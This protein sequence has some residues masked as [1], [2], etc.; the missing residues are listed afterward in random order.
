MN[1][2][3]Q[4]LANEAGSAAEHLGLGA[5]S[6][7]RANYAQKAYYTQ[8]FFALSVGLE[9]ACKLILVVDHAIAKGKFPTNQEVRRYGHNLLDLMN[10]ADKVASR[11]QVS[12]EERMPR[13]DIH[14]GVIGTLSDLPA[15]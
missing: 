2:V 5:T 1:E 3:W 10:A 4:A 15:T 11:L 6:L 12:D 9:R 13:S 8:S 14:D 7:G